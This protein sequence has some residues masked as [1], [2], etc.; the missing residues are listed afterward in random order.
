MNYLDP[1]YFLIEIEFNASDEKGINIVRTKIT[2]FARKSLCNPDKN[3]PC[4]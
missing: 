3:Y 1:K 2:D 4:P